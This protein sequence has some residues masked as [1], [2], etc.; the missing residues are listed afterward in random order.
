[1]ILFGTSVYFC[2]I[3]Y[4]YLFLFMLKQLTAAILL[5][6]FMASSFCRTVVV[7]DY[8]A[9]TAAYAKACINK[10]RLAM[11]CN[12]KCQMMK[13]LEQ[14]EKNDRE[15]LER[16]AEN[17]NEIPPANDFCKPIFLHEEA[18]RHAIAGITVQKPVDRSYALL[19]PPSVV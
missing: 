5:L 3:L 4:Q 9:N 16:K 7:L 12:G 10:A 15:N 11:H 6:S 1:M 19:R 2:S 18:T 13:K 8:F 14:E 17:K